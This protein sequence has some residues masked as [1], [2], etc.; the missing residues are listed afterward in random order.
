M[1]QHDI[2]PLFVTPHHIVI[3]CYLRLQFSYIVPEG[4]TLVIEFNSSKLTFIHQ[5][6]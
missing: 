5:F 2:V 1:F 6:A 4:L 3:Q